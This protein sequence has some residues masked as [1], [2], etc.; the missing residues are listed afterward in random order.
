MI[1]RIMMILGD[2]PFSMQT[3]AYDQFQHSTQY[4]WQSQERLGGKPSPQFTGFGE[5]TINLSGLMLPD[6]AGGVAQLDAMRASADKGVPLILIDGNGYV[7]G[8]FCIKKISNTNN[9]HWSNGM[10][11]KI[12][13][14][15]ELLAYNQD[16]KSNSNDWL[17]DLKPVQVK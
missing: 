17:N 5:E 9:Y 14:S 1:S 16:D 7:K 4:N 13:F 15:M 8:K 10:A 3:A 6:F 2:Y 12:E 11:R